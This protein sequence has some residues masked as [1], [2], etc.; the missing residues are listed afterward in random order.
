MKT[1]LTGHWKNLLMLNYEVPPSILLP[2]LPKG[3]ELDFFDGKCYA[4]L[5]GFMFLNT[6]LKG[7]PIPFHRNFEEVNLRF[8]VRFK[9][10]KEWKRGVVFIKEIVPKKMITLVANILYGEQYDNMPMKNS[11]LEQA[12]TFEVKYQWLFNKQWNFL[13]AVAYKNNQPILHGSEEEFITEHYWGYSKL[14]DNTTSEYR[15]NHPQ[16]KVHTVS[17][18]DLQ[19]NVGKLYGNQFIEPLSQHPTSVLLAQG[20]DVSINHRKIWKY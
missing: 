12:D 8:Y 20:S 16:W 7:I 2:F 15:V 11:L 3:C 1:F 10:G 17:S 18:Y 4:S 6:K 13:Q 9:D 19:C 5:V 14:N